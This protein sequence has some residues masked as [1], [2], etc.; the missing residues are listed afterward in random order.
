MYVFPMTVGS[1]SLFISP[2]ASS[3]SSQL[4]NGLLISSAFAKLVAFWICNTTGLVGGL[5][6]PMIISSLMLARVII[7]WTG[8]NSVLGLSCG[9][10]ALTTA[11]VP[12]PFA[13]VLL[14]YISLTL[15]QQGLTPILATALTSYLCFVGVGIPQAF[16]AV[17]AKNEAKEKKLEEESEETTATV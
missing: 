8:I 3:N 9:F 15:G 6:F 10:V 14:S 2:V 17:K 4:D 1:G 12:S 16:L 13:F 5:V 11:I 7:N